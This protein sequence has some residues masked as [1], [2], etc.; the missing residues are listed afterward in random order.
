MPIAI[1]AEQRA[2]QASIREWATRA[3][4]LALVRGLEPGGALGLPRD[5]AR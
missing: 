1:C 5:E 3:G 4:T 2:L